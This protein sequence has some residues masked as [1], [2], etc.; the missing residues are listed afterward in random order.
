M[1]KGKYQQLFDLGEEAIL[2]I[3]RDIRAGQPYAAI[4]KKVQQAGQLKELKPRKLQ[5][6]LQDYQKDVMDRSLMKR[7]DGMGLLSV[8]RTAARINSYDELRNI[9]AVQRL[10]VEN[11]M[12]AA[13]KTPGLLVEQHGRE[14]ER[15]HK[16]LLGMVQVEMD[17]G[18]VAKASRK[19]TGQ[20]IRDAHNPNRVSFE[21]TEETVQAADEVEQLLEGEFVDALALPAPDASKA[22]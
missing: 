19:V 22:A 6:L 13:S 15:Y 2:L 7:I 8:Q 21:L 20:L 1:A 12:E 11:A 14:F 9:A 4:A 5:R 3:E 10:R 17:L 16:M 18:I